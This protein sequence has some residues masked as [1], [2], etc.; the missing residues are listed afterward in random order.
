M[1]G[2]TLH[3]F[4]PPLILG[5]ALGS[6]T[7]LSLSLNDARIP[8][9][10]AAAPQPNTLS[11]AA[12]QAEVDAL[13][14]DVETLKAKAPDQAHAMISAAYH[15][16]NLWFAA[17]EGNWPLAQFYLNETKSHLHWAVRIIP[18]R[19]DNQGREV[20]LTAILEAV[21]NSLFPRIQQAVD[22]KD[23]EAFEAA[24]ELTLNDGCYSCH[25]ASDKPYL[26]LHLPGSPAER[27]I[28]GATTES[29]QGGSPQRRTTFQNTAP[30]KAHAMLIEPAQLQERLD[31]PDWRILDTRSA[32]DYAK[33]HIPGAVRVEVR[34]WQNLGR[35]EGGFHNTE[36]WA[37]K[38]G[39]LGIGKDSHVVVYGTRLSDAARIWWTL[40]YLGL[41]NVTLLN[42][43][44]DA[45]SRQER[46]LTNAI[47][48][49]ATVPFQPRFQPDRLEEI[50]TLKKSLPSG[51]V[52]VVDARSTDEFTGKEVR[53]K[54][55]GH[56][57]GATHLEWKE[58][59]APDGRFKTREQLK[60]LFRKRGILPT[61]PAVCY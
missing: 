36:A 45:W 58:L 33:G 51:N 56:I 34:D 59:L 54:R 48:K 2:S 40:K 18:V 61:E 57:P 30:P 41:G 24:Y 42:G 4:L 21:E 35:S 60:E 47:P 25:K 29:A 8:A 31:D 6:V 28:A 5:F 10:H 16:N 38:V 15:F 53:G 26:Q 27:L 12:L 1:S 14:T 50:E 7:V 11:R 43:G 49:I 44:W 3:R 55:G 23:R 37:E 39:R 22:A 19:K 20:E 46:P 17:H 13:R 32:D 52:Q 9:A